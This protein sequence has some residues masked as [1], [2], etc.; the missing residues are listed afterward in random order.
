MRRRRILV[1]TD[2][3]PR[4]QRA[5]RFAARLARR[6]GAQLVGVYVILERAP[7]LFDATL[8]ASPA[9]SPALRRT[10]RRQADGALLAV[11]REARRQRVPCQCMRVHG[12]RGWKAILG[13]A[14]RRHCDVI[15]AA[16]GEARPLLRHSRL[17]VLVC[18]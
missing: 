15:V 16:P 18:R 12:T 4:A 11:E 17:P 7:T 9:L 5:A 3:S 10:I 2:G 14:H 1:A 13:A 8:Y 6:T